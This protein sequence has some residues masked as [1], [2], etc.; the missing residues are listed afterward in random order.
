MLLSDYAA[1]LHREYAAFHLDPTWQE[2]GPLYKPTIRP[3]SP[4]WNMDWAI[5]FPDGY[6]AYVYERWYTS[7]IW[8]PGKPR[9]GRREHFSFHYGRANHVLKP[10]GIPEKDKV[11]CPAIIRIDCDMWGPHLHFHNES[12]HINQ[13]RVQ[14]MVIQDSDPF[15]FMR[16]VIEHRNTG[17]DFDSIMHFTVTP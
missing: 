15:E 8:I 13:Q 10:N 4:P 14:G 3:N 2:I 6:Y 11:N 9:P 16:A 1:R 5:I 7:G 17:R 12:D